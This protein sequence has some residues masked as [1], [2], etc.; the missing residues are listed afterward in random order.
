MYCFLLSLLNSYIE[1]SCSSFKDE[2]SHIGG[3][4]IKNLRTPKEMFKLLST[5]QEREGSKI[6]TSSLTIQQSKTELFKVC[7]AACFQLHALI[8]K[9]KYSN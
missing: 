5:S 2:L 8:T 9:T 1:N 3:G 6:L 7:T 4:E